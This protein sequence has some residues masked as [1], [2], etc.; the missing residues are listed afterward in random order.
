MEIMIGNKNIW[1]QFSV[2]KREERKIEVLLNL[3]TNGNKRTFNNTEND[4]P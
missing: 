4:V 2:M 1:F 3:Y